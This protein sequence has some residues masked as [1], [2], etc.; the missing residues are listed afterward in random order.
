[1]NKIINYIFLFIS[2][3]LFA[4]KPVSSAVDSTAIHI[5]SAFTYSIEAQGEK[6][7]KIT[8]PESEQIGDFEVLES[9]PI[10]TLVQ[11]QK[12]AYIKKYLLTQ[13]DSGSY[14]IDR[15][16]VYIN[17]KNYQTDLHKIEV[18]PVV[19]D[20]LKQPMYDIKTVVGSSVD[21]SYMIYYIIAAL[22]CVI[23]GLLV[24]WIIKKQ[25]EKHLTEDDLFRTPLEKATA[26]LK[27]LDEKRW[28][29]DGNVKGY[30]SELTDIAREYIEEVFEIPAKESTS[31]DLIRLLKQTVKNKKIKLRAQTIKDLQTVLQTADLVKFAKSEPMLSEV[32][33]DRKVVEDITSIT[34]KAIPKFSEE[35]S[36]RVKKREQR[37]RK[38]KQIRTWVP[39]GTSL[40]LL[41]A[42][43]AVYAYSSLL[44]NVNFSV[45]ASNKKLYKQEWVTSSYGYPPM[46]IQTPEALT[47][48]E[49]SAT[50]TENLQSPVANFIYQ[51]LS[52]KLAITLSTTIMQVDEKIDM[53][54]LLKNKLNVLETAFLATDIQAD[55]D[56][57]TIQ[58]VN[59]IHAKGS[60]KGRLGENEE[61]E[62]YDF[63]V[64]IFAQKEGIQELA[65]MFK[66]D[67]E[68]GQKI[69]DRIFE[70]VQF[71][72]NQE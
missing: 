7:A 71:N 39:I 11:E 15:Q 72:P 28:I 3:G 17:G 4:Q 10:D 12:T 66:K 46:Q 30:Y 51:N 67:D 2:F 24:F 70:S 6:N 47:R 27:H 25:Q 5:G 35:Q 16:S 48:V 55:N 59:G 32:E 22:A 20:T 33:K 64:F 21:T 41:L 60:F 44:D 29:T 57:I 52:T 65:V 34:D 31:S 68:Y 43:G 23:I 1:M 18:L 9:Y 36:E 8:F 63:E 53:D 14:H 54:K 38:R 61:A 19:V 56:K 42:V 69:A 50:K 37:Y 49:T 62:E 58:G 40:V 13:F 45:F 26:K